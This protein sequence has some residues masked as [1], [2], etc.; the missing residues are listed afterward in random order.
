MDRSFDS[1]DFDSPDFGSPDAPGVTGTVLAGF[2]GSPE[3]VAASEWAAREARLRGLPL[4]LLLAWPWPK[5]EER[6]QEVEQLAVREAEL[7]ASHPEVAINSAHVPTAP[8]EALEEAGRRA[9][10]LVLGSRG[11]GTVRGFLV[12]SVSQEVLRRAVCPVVLVRGGGAAPGAVLVGVDLDRPAD[13]L[14]A[15]AFE[16]AALR[17]APLRVLHVWAPPPGT[18]YMHFDAIGGLEGEVSEA[19]RQR[20]TEA[21]APWRARHPEVEVSTELTRGKAGIVLVE[22]A[23]TGTD[24]GLLVLG[25]HTRRGPLRHHLGSVA[26]AAI[27]H[28]HCPI[29]FV[30]LP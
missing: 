29:A 16:E 28:V 7:R 20:F 23:G 26:H 21:L 8:P 27:H 14:L 24:V 10:M 19:E 15:F 18:E 12:G 1:P 6:R 17:S 3:S 11:L 2:D 5:R 9:G 4:E 22:A 25:R 13:D 30:P